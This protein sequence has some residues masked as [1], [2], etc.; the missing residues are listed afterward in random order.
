MEKEIER[1]TVELVLLHKNHID[2]EK[3]SL[4]DIAYEISYGKMIGDWSIKTTE[5]ILGY[6]AIDQ[7]A[8]DLRSSG[9][10]FFDLS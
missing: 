4:S 8:S 2:V 9:E 7:A 5:T 10:F 1:T 3:L 6:Q